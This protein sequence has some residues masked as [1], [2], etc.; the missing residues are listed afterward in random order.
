MPF[1]KS[2]MHCSDS[3]EEARPPAGSEG[4]SLADVNIL[5]S[6][7]VRGVP[8]DLYKSCMNTYCVIIRSTCI[9][10]ACE[11]TKKAHTNKT[12]HTHRH[13]HTHAHTHT[14]THTQ[15]HAPTHTH[16]HTHTYTRRTH[17][18][19]HT[20]ANKP[21]HKYLHANYICIKPL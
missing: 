14:Y 13:T 7:R 19:A 18:H 11:S 9:R 10:Q 6:D 20:N 17:T 3:E 5:Q 2:L 15:T 1:Q 8:E 12:T 21:K 4:Q 16:T